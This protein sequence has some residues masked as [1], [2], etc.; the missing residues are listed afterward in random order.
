[1]QKYVRLLSTRDI[2][3][4]RP[5]TNSDRA[6]RLNPY[7]S[8]SVFQ[9]RIL[10]RVNLLQLL[11]LVEFIILTFTLTIASRRLRNVGSYRYF[12]RVYFYTKVII[13]SCT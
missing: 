11:I 6:I 5:K 12:L 8:I 9:S 13:T 1:M 10:Y 3:P 7:Y 4:Q 2:I